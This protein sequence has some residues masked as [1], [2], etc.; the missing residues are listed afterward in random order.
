MR[1][2]RYVRAMERIEPAE[3]LAERTLRAIVENAEE[4]LEEQS[5][6]RPAI[7]EMPRCAERT[8]RLTRRRRHHRQRLAACLILGLTLVLSGVA[9][10]AVPLLAT[11][12]APLYGAEHL[13]ITDGPILQE[14]G[15]VV[16]AI[17]GQLSL[18]WIEEEKGE[19]LTLSFD[20]PD[21]LLAFPPI[22]GEPS[23]TSSA[24]STL[25]IEHPRH[26]LDLTL[27]L[28]LDNLDSATHR[29][30]IATDAERSAYRMLREMELTLSQL[31]T[32]TLRAT[33]ED[34]AVKTYAF[35]IEQL[36][37]QWSY[38]A[39]LYQGGPLSINLVPTAAP[40]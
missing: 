1:T 23:T 13:R 29:D 7:R 19:S 39:R 34:G 20:D 33:T 21:L 27:F 18:P 9:I 6:E 16:L 37:T 24:S 28:R 15:T 40:S 30:L 14:N 10:P 38:T 12:F 11:A 35:D 32:A 26:S 36:E 3:G 5:A 4:P 22:D 31:E 17:H 25:T 8:S 2:N